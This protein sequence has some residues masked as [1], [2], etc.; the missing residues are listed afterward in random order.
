MQSQSG[1]NVDE[2]FRGGDESANQQWWSCHFGECAIVHIVALCHA[3]FRSEGKGRC[4]KPYWIR[5][6]GV[7]VAVDVG[8][9][10]VGE[11]VEGVDGAAS[12]DRGGVTACGD[13]LV[14]VGC[15]NKDQ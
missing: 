6:E 2:N 13:E 5:K 10:A 15:I 8:E 3:S 7:R 1:S 4:L 9:G 14:I 12:G 11:A